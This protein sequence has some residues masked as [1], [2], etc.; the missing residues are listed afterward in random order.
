[1][2]CSTDRI[3]VHQIENV[4]TVGAQSAAHINNLHPIQSRKSP[5]VRRD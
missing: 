2:N 1:M 4:N 3:E 5:V